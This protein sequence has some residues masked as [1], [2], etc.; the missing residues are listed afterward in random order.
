MAQFDVYRNPNP[1]SRKFAPYLVCLQSDFTQTGETVVVAPLVRK[2]DPGLK[3]QL[4]YSVQVDEEPY[5]VLFASLSAIAPHSLGTPVAVLP[6]LKEA[7]VK[8]VDLLFI[9]F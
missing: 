5:V 8:A 4:Q 7:M 2:A 1:A 3:A 9:G 6:E